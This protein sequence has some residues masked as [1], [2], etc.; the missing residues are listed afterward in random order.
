M[1]ERAYIE[2]IDTFPLLALEPLT[3]ASK[4]ALHVDGVVTNIGGQAASGAYLFAAIN[5]IKLVLLRL[6]I[7]VFS[8]PAF[9]LVALVALF[10]GLVMRDIR[11]YTGGHESSYVFHKAKRLVV[12]S[13][14]LTIAIYLML[15]LSVPPVAVFGPTLILTG[16]AIYT[17]TS[18][19]KKYL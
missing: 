5:T 7:C 1:T 6:V 10:D 11:K 9:A 8:A 4:A 16:A 18:R 12:P 17:A 14:A 3:L 13:V 19:F 15:P 2:A